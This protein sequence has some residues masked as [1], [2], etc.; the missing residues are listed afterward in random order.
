MN[1][2]AIF[3][4]RTVQLRNVKKFIIFVDKLDFLLYNITIKK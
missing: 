2:I 4:S 3:N 1:K